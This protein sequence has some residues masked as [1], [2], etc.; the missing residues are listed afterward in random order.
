MTSFV[1][2]MT[3]NVCIPLILDRNMILEDNKISL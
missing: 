2:S 1:N 3:E